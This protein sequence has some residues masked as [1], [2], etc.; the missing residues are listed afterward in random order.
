MAEKSS[1]E[2]RVSPSA[3]MRQLRPE[4]Y[5]DTEDHTAYQLDSAH[6]ETHNKLKYMKIY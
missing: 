3:F 5:S 6:P 1:R 2:N 4:Y